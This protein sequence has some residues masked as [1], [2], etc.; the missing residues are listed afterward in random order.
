MGFKCNYCPKN[1]TLKT[2][3]SRHERN[4]HAVE[5]DLPVFT[6][7]HCKFSSLLLSKLQQHFESDHQKFNKICR[8]CR[9]GF[10][11]LKDFKD[12]MQSEHGLPVL[13]QQFTSISNP[14]SS[15]TQTSDI[16]NFSASIEVQ[17]SAL[18]NTL[19][20]FIFPNQN[21]E[22]YLIKFMTLIKHATV[23]SD[24]SVK[25]PEDERI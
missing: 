6:C 16:D 10:C 4:F 3:R 7:Y 5:K 12:H 15:I 20:T 25:Q 23:V 18:K 14:S 11:E 21:I 13:D 8:Y 2:N 9:L 19:K 22:H 1:F 24:Q 17:D